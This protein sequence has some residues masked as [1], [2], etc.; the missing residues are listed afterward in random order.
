LQPTEYAFR[1]TTKER[2]KK[3]KMNERSH[4]QRELGRPKRK[5]GNQKGY[6]LGDTVLEKIPGGRGAGGGN[7]CLPTEKHDKKWERRMETT[8]LVRTRPGHKTEKSG[9]STQRSR[10]GRCKESLWKAKRGIKIIRTP[11][12]SNIRGQRGGKKEM[13][14]ISKKERKKKLTSP[15]QRQKKN[16]KLG[17]GKPF[18]AKKPGGEEE[19]RDGGG[20]GENDETWRRKGN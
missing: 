2:T 12:A 18:A 16:S 11:R 5:F 7:K 6:R 17:A 13:R 9:G 19:K 14:N 3:G 4:G 15:L 20:V 8:R 1:S 10:P